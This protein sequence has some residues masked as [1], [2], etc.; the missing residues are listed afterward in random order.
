[1]TAVECVVISTKVTL[2]KTML[3]RMI[4]CHSTVQLDLLVNADYSSNNYKSTLEWCTEFQYTTSVFSLVGYVAR[5]LFRCRTAR[6]FVWSTVC[7]VVFGLSRGFRESH[8]QLVGRKD[9]GAMTKQFILK[10]Q[11]HLWDDSLGFGYTSLG[12]CSSYWDS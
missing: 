9:P 10:L 11:L 1:M 7:R 3:R 8:G 12:I 5:W 2:D 4:D 6:F